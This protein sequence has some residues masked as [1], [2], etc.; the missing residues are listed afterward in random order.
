MDTPEEYSL[1]EA[2]LKFAKQTNGK[3]W[4]LLDKPNRSAD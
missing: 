1:D 4:N 2:Q 3:V